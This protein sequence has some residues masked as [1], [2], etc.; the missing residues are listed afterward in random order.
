MVELPV[1]GTLVG[2][3][4]AGLVDGQ[5]VKVL[6]QHR[7][8]AGEVRPARRTGSAAVQQHDRLLFAN[9]SLVIVQLE[10]SV[11]V[12]FG[13]AGGGLEGELFRRASS[14]HGVAG[15]QPE[16]VVTEDEVGPLGV[17]GRVHPA[18]VRVTPEALHRRVIGQRRGTG[19]LE[20]PVD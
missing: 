14:D 13:E 18:G 11:N 4:V 2:V 10:R 9:A 15:R 1:L 5:H 8:V 7:D 20:Q 17:V 6:R 3:A 12:D 16:L 19:S